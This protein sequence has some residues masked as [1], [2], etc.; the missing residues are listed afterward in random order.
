[1]CLFCEIACLSFH[2][3]GMMQ[4]MSKLILTIKSTS[5]LLNLL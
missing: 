1:M 2:S 3:T 4:K 5:Y